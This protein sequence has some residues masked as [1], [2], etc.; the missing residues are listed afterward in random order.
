MSHIFANLAGDFAKVD[1]TQESSV[2]AEFL[3]HLCQDQVALAFFYSRISDQKL[4]PAKLQ[5]MLG[6]S[7]PPIYQQNKVNKHVSF[8]Y[9]DLHAICGF[10]FSRLPPFDYSTYYIMTLKEMWKLWNDSLAQQFSELVVPEKGAR[11]FLQNLVSFS[12]SE[13]QLFTALYPR[14][15]YLLET[16]ETEAIVSG[17]EFRCLGILDELDTRVARSFNPNWITQA[18]FSS[19]WQYPA[20]I[21]SDEFGKSMQT[22][23]VAREPFPGPSSMMKTSNLLTLVNDVLVR[24]RSFADSVFK[25]SHSLLMAREYETLRK[26]VNTIQSLKPWVFLVDYESIAPDEEFVVEVLPNYECDEWPF[27][28]DE[29]IKNDIALKKFVRQVGSDWNA[30]ESLPRALQEAIDQVDLHN[31]NFLSDN[32]F[33]CFSEEDRDQDFGFIFTYRALS[34]VMGLLQGCDI[35]E[36]VLQFCIH[37]CRDMVGL[38]I[39]IFSLI[40]LQKDNKFVFSVGDAVKILTALLPFHKEDERLKYIAV[41]FAKVQKME[42]LEAASLDDC[43]VSNLGTVMTALDNKEWEL[44]MCSVSD[45][46]TVKTVCETAK[47]VNE[48]MNGKDVQ[49]TELSQLEYALSTNKDISEARTNNPR[50]KHLLQSREIGATPAEILDSIHCDSYVV[51]MLKSIEARVG[52]GYNVEIDEKNQ[53]L[54]HFFEYYGKYARAVKKGERSANIIDSYI[55]SEDVKTWSQVEDMFGENA[56]ES[57]LTSCNLDNPS[58]QFI[59]LIEQASPVMGKTMRT[60]KHTGCEKR[61]SL[62]SLELYV[63]GDQALIDLI[64]GKK[65]QENA[66]LYSAWEAT[67]ARLLVLILERCRQQKLLSQDLLFALLDL[68]IENEGLGNELKSSLFNAVTEC[69]PFPSEFCWELKMYMPN[70]F[71]ENKQTFY[72]K[73]DGAEFYELYPED[74]NEFTY[75]LLA[76]GIKRGTNENIIEQLLAKSE[77]V[78][79]GQFAKVN[80]LS[81]FFERALTYKTQTMIQKNEDVSKLYEQERSFALYVYNRLPEYMRNQSVHNQMFG[82]TIQNETMMPESEYDMGMVDLSSVSSIV[83]FA[84][85]Y[86][87]NKEEAT[88]SVNKAA[89][90]IV[91]ELAVDSRN[92]EMQAL[93][94]IRRLHTA[95]LTLGSDLAPKFGWLRSFLN[96]CFYARFECPYSLQSVVD[97]PGT[98]FDICW[99]YDE[100]GLAEA[101]ASIW[102]IPMTGKLLQV[103]HKCFMLGQT[104]SAIPLVELQ[105]RQATKVTDLEDTKRILLRLVPIEINYNPEIFHVEMVPMHYRVRC[106]ING[107]GVYINKDNFMIVDRVIRAF[108]GVPELIKFKCLSGDFSSVFNLVTPAVTVDEW[109]D[110]V[111]LPIIGINKWQ[112]FWKYLDR[113]EAA[114]LKF[115]PVSSS[116]CSYLQKQRIMHTLFDIQLRL[117]MREDAILTVTEM[118]DMLDSWQ[119]RLKYSTELEDLI[120]KELSERKQGKRA[121]KVSDRTLNTL[122]KKTSMMREFSQACVV[123]RLDFDKSLDLINS[124]KAIE[125]AAFAALYTH[126]F[127]LGIRICE[128]KPESLKTVCERLVDTLNCAGSDASGKYLKAME[129][130]ITG[131]EYE[132]LAS[133]FA[134]ACESRMKNK[135]DMPK[136][137]KSNIAN[138]DLQVKLLLKFGFLAD[139]KQAC[140]NKQLMLL[141]LNAAMEAGN[142][143][144]ANECKKALGK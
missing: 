82:V 44:A 128:L 13:P 56:L 66:K 77:M 67:D 143:K 115:K 69:T 140:Q 78:L 45:G 117:G 59:E 73:L 50:V 104:L 55:R 106:I 105:E 136:F 32:K 85:N 119:S 112:E 6:V 142:T 58:D 15:K 138:N 49:M 93:K 111:F 12:S 137:I 3:R 14:V 72:E 17:L 54:K 29:R 10:Y 41:A 103:C 47:L 71:A 108:G 30:E 84:N 126:Q 125:P 109:I 123:C 16:M 120:T 53:H 88:K 31:I 20:V 118:G 1:L 70:Q 144:L 37:K 127:A 68:G 42:I 46:S 90:D 23:L 130:A 26:V 121:Q 8:Y 132:K 83:A 87:G 129:K 40:F 62:A 48:Q 38:V 60:L 19:F 39:D 141:I 64:Q 86:H 122:L 133:H 92:S 74:A 2:E 65:S 110:D 24:R 114:M 43:F 33:L 27:R 18:N 7:P 89:L 107:S 97:S 34:S 57:V 139:A 11:A 101:A 134:V 5:L 95:L 9:Q 94:T 4:F 35:D 36:E 124:D 25:I 131:V 51:N 28:M 99:Q 75:C 22:V 81:A 80:N 113:N 91:S 100:E 102:G 61:L 52:E 63:Q 96:S 79:A 76:K 116:L 135:K 21:M 98:L